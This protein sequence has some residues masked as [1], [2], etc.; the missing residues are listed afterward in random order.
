MKVS[1]LVNSL[2]YLFERLCYDA[3]Y[4]ITE[5]NDEDAGNYTIEEQLIGILPAGCKYL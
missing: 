2:L 3:R 1:E 4:Q 5:Q